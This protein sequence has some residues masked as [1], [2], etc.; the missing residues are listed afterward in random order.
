MRTCVLVTL[1]LTTLPPGVA[2]QC[3]ASRQNR[4]SFEPQARIDC[5]AL[6]QAC[7]I[8]D[9]NSDR[10]V[11]A[12]GVLSSND[13]CTV[14]V[15]PLDSASDGTNRC[16]VRVDA[17]GALTRSTRGGWPPS[18]DVNATGIQASAEP[19]TER[20]LRNC[21]AW[22]GDAPYDT[23]SDEWWQQPGLFTC[24]GY[25]RC[26]RS[27]CLPDA[28]QRATLRP[29]ADQAPTAAPNG[30]PGSGQAPHGSAG[31]EPGASLPQ[32]PRAPTPAQMPRSAAPTNRTSAQAPVAPVMPSSLPA[33]APASVRAA[34]PSDPATAAA[35]AAA[36]AAAPA[37]SVSARAAS[38]AQVSEERYRR[39][40]GIAAGVASA[41]VL[42]LVVL[43]IAGLVYRCRKR[44]DQRMLA[45]TL[46]TPLPRGKGDDDSSNA[47][48]KSDALVDPCAAAGTS[49]RAASLSRA[50]ASAAYT[51]RDYTG[52][53]NSPLLPK[54]TVE[55]NDA[56][57]R[58]VAALQ[59]FAAAEPPHVFAGKYLLLDERVVGGQAVVNFAR[60]PGGS[61]DSYAIKCDPYSICIRGMSC[62]G[63]P[64]ACPG[65][66]AASLNAH[67]GF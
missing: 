25:S 17:G 7:N 61:I 43:S 47:Q 32:P 41:C 48:C 40:V 49:L 59:T 16:S 26:S 14:T 3:Q 54:R 20:F 12:E 45:T 27:L 52:S 42:L 39:H 21:A 63:T 67:T 58:L 28:Q 1:A 19:L 46:A 24:Y 57:A 64:V 6:G 4:E 11:T 65:L 53:S 31:P 29:S 38:A 51:S 23:E 55:N 8:A 15:L 60:G 10:S 2:A 62:D 35:S 33:P 37:A 44:P 50:H 5:A 18:G 13:D 36:P 9:L 22:C 56:H 34:Q 30:S 66:A